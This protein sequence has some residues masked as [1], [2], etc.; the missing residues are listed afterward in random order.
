M[1]WHHAALTVDGSGNAILYL[2][3]AQVATAMGANFL[4]N[5]ANATSMAIGIND[6][7]GGGRQWGFDGLL[8]DVR[9]Y[10]GALS[11]VE[12][13]GLIPIYCRDE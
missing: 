7:S 12:I 13:D 5:V 3:G 9:V 11:A 1:S 10:D 4:D 6:D 2:D 8:S